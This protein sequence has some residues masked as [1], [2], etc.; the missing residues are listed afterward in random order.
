MIILLMELL[1]PKMVS[2]CEVQTIQPSRLLLADGQAVPQMEGIPQFSNAMPHS[3][4]IS[5]GHTSGSIHDRVFSVDLPAFD[6]DSAS[7]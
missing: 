1:A 4:H 2:K 3:H 5:N 7:R 6:V